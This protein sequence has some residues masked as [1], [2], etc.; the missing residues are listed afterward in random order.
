MA[1]TPALSPSHGLSRSL[2]LSAAGEKAQWMPFF[3]ALRQCAA[4][5]RCKPFWQ[6]KSGLNPLFNFFSSCQRLGLPRHLHLHLLSRS[7]MQLELLAK[8][9]LSAHVFL[10]LSLPLCRRPSPSLCLC[11]SL[12]S[13]EHIAISW[14]CPLAFKLALTLHSSLDATE[15]QL[16][17]QQP[18][19]LPFSLPTRNYCNEKLVKIWVH[20]GN[21]VIPKCTHNKS[22]GNLQQVDAAICL[23]I[24]P[25]N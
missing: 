25:T 7:C 4:F 11:L 2:P 15:M 6:A 1:H 19:H 13:N 16:H 8:S 12:W 17:H 5:Q 10:S 21:I 23:A 22:R 14:I 3:F 20:C 9:L 24:L 18:Q